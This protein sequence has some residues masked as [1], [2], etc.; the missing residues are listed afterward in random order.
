MAETKVSDSGNQRENRG[1]YKREDIDPLQGG[2]PGEVTDDSD[3][4][5]SGSSKSLPSTYNKAAADA[6]ILKEL[7]DA[8]NIQPTTKMKAE[9][10]KGLNA[11]LKAYG[12]T[13]SSRSSSSKKTSSSTS[14]SVT[15]ADADVYVK[16]FIAEVVKDTLKAN[17]KVKFGG[18]VGDTI[19]VLNKYSADMGIFKSAGE[20]ARNSI[21]VLAGKTRQEDL[22]TRYSKDAQALYANFA[23]RL[24]ED[25]SLTVRELANPYIEMMADTFEDVADNIKLTDDTIQRA[26]NDA[27]GIMSLGNFRTML[28]ND[29]RFGK[30]SGA[31]REAAEL[32]M[33]MIRSMGF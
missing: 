27:K 12:S 17:P 6:L 7:V 10:F 24:K 9:F 18:K 29:S 23:P 8:L 19:A 16:Q 1:V 33:S 26:I 4:P 5:S 31:K 30:T 20:I 13:T 15:G 22:L 3:K 28:R 14:S 2:D 11:F 25:A 32:G 21:D